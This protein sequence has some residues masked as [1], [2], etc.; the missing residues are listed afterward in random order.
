[1]N[2][3]RFRSGL[4]ALASLA[5]VAGC[6]S[7]TD[8]IASGAPTGTVTIWDY[9]GSS[10]PIK[11]AIAAF[12][13]SHPEIKVNYEAFDYQTM[14]DR[15]SVAASSGDAPDLATLDM[16]WVP[17]YAANGVLSDI[18]A[19]SGGLLNLDPPVL[20]SVGPDRV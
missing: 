11:P 8:P 6:T 7:G 4:V 18:G 19:I 9:Y 3:P 20:V 2:R 1:M 17:T 14:Q 16:T 12:T 13:K 15:F 10:A 5:L